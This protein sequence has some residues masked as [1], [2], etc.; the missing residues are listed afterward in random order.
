LAAVCTK[1]EAVANPS[2]IG[3]TPEFS[4]LVREYFQPNSFELKPDVLPV[5]YNEAM[6][7]D[8]TRVLAEI[9]SKR[10]LFAKL[11]DEIWE[12]VF[13]SLKQILSVLVSIN[14]TLQRKGPNDTKRCVEQL[15]T[16]IA[17]Y[18]ASYEANYVRFMEGPWLRNLASAHKERNWPALGDAAEDLIRL[19]RLFGR[20]LKNLAAFAHDG[21]ILSW[22]DEESQAAEEPAGLSRWARYARNRKL[23]DTCGWDLNHYRRA[24]CPYNYTV[25][26][27]FDPSETA[28]EYEA[29]GARAVEVAGS[30]LEW[31]PIP[32][33]QLEYGKWAARMRIRSGVYEYKFIVDGV[34]QIDPRSRVE[35]D[36][37]GNMNSVLFVRDS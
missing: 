14:R 8:L 26:P 13:Q 36:S 6:L 17:S 9:R 31:Q 12:Y 33:E 34:W 29:Y 22:V 7:D 4:Q 37:A 30:F 20:A 25:C 27:S 16:A 18:L 2:A 32:L 19:R 1:I 10:V 23:C 24:K 11:D 5:K 35:R 28:F 15:I 3:P 21:E